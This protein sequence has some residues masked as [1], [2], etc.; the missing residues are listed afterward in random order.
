MLPPPA[1]TLP[2][3]AFSKVSMAVVFNWQPGLQLAIGTAPLMAT[4]VL[5]APTAQAYLTSDIT[6]GFFFFISLIELSF[7][8]FLKNKDSGLVV[9]AF[10][11]LVF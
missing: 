9:Q 8:M 6:E 2:W 11:F 3:K 4:T 5:V 10:Q 7:L 1:A